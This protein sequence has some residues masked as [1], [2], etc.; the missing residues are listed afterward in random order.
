MKKHNFPYLIHSVL[1]SGV[2]LVLYSL[3]FLI[4]DRR[5]AF[6]YGHL[7]STPFDFRTASRYWM[8]GLVTSGVV[9]IVYTVVNLVTKKISRHY[10]LPDWKVI[11]KYG[12]LILVLPLFVILTFVGKPPIPAL[13]SFWILTVLFAGLKLA[14]YASNFIV[15]NFRQSVF[16][17]FDGLALVPI[18]LFI[19]LGIEF[20]L[21]RSLPIVLVITLVVIV[22]MAL[23]GFWI[24]TLLYKRFKQPY[25]SSINIFLSGLTTA[26]LLLPLYHYLTSRPNH[27]YISDSGNF[28]ASSIW[29]QVTAFLTAVG[30]IW[31]INKWRGKKASDLDHVKKLLFTLVLLTVGGFL[32]IWATT[33]KETDVWLCKEDQWVKQGNPP[34]EKPFDEECGIIDKAMGVK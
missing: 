4:L 1:I 31:L 16:A 5:F 18:L 25:P 10:Q 12:C 11:W 21:R 24:L 9:L 34:Y 14:L 20:G 29:L 27:I 32:A 23:F 15:A 2:V 30:I 22:G 28:F 19:P 26:Y 33:G 8:T 6:L 17:F 7:H 3:W 13:L